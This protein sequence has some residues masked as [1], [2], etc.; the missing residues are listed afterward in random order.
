[1]KYLEAANN[2]KPGN[3]YR[4]SYNQ[5]VTGIHK[6]MNYSVVLYKQP[7]VFGPVAGKF[8]WNSPFVFLE[9]LTVNTELTVGR[10]KM[11]KLLTVEGVLGWIALDNLCTY[12][13]AQMKKHPAKFV[14]LK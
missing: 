10:Y 14:E 4:V 13:D 2:L 8:Y 3:L 12:T 11:T 5:K 6:R 1:M 9:T 7:N